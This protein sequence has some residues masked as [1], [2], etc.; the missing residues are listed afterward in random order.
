[1]AEAFPWSRLGQP[2]LTGGQLA[3]RGQRALR[4]IDEWGVKVPANSRLQRAI[5]IVGR[6]LDEPLPAADVVPEAAKTILD[7]HF[8]IHAQAERP[9]DAVVQRLTAALS[10]GDVAE[11][12]ADKRPRDTQFELEVWATLR[13]G[14]VDV[15]FEE[16]DLV[17]RADDELIGIAVKRIWSLEQAHKR[18]SDGAA[19]IERSKRQGL[20][21]TNVQQYL[22]GVGAELEL[23]AKGRSFNID[24][25]RLHG[26]LAYL[27]KKKH[28]IGI[29]LR[30]TGSKPSNGIPGQPRA[31]A[32]A[33]Y[34]QTFMFLDEDDPRDFQGLFGRIGERLAEWYSQNL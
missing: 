25:R 10:G 8:I 14:G 22:T 26:Q 30:G 28:V 7:F 21:A 13:I 29:I 9:P 24:V 33:T 18:L 2:R 16:P 1:V 27:A 32:L 31:V 34:T 15:W 3:E 20:I 23:A 12:D 19:Q 5:E 17:F 11:T 4:R 6:K